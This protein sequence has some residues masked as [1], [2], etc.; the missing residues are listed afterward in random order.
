MLPG[1]SDDTPN[2]AF[3]SGPDSAAANNAVPAGAK[4]ASTL[5]QLLVLNTAHAALAGPASNAEGHNRVNQNVTKVGARTDG[6]NGGGGGSTT[7][8]ERLSSRVYCTPDAKQKL[9]KFD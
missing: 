8:V 4:P 9:K 3:S 1:C 7:S 2:D 6:D 5:S